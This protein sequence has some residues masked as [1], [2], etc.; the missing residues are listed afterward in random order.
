MASSRQAK[1]DGSRSRRVW[2]NLPSQAIVKGT[3]CN[4]EVVPGQEFDLKRRCC[5]DVETESQRRIVGVFRIDPGENQALISCNVGR[6]PRAEYAWSSRSR[7]EAW[8]R[9]SSLSICFWLQSRR[10]ANSA[11]VTPCPR[12]SR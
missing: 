3:R 5:D 1:R 9:S 7:R 4:L 8:R 10:R 12:I 2:G 11:L 6:L